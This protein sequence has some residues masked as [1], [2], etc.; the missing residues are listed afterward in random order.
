[1][2]ATQFIKGANDRLAEV[3]MRNFYTVR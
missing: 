3:A 2:A 1:V